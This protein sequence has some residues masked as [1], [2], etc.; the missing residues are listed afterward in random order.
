[1]NK[2]Y[3]KLVTDINRKSDLDNDLVLFLSNFSTSSYF[4]GSLYFKQRFWSSSLICHGKLPF[5][6]IPL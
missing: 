3:K 6:P 1:M 5:I 2:S 4:S